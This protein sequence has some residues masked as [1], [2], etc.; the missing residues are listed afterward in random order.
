MRTFTSLILPSIFLLQSSCSN[1]DIEIPEFDIYAAKN[2]WEYKPLINNNTLNLD[3]VELS[4]EPFL[5]L[6]KIGRY[7]TAN[8]IIMLKGSKYDL[9]YPDMR[10]S[11]QLFVVSINK[12]PVYG[13]FFWDINSSQPCRW[14][15]ILKPPDGI[16]DNQIKIGLGYATDTIV[17]TDPRSDP[18]VIEAFRKSGKL[19]YAPQTVVFKFAGN[20]GRLVVRPA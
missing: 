5:T 9:K 14:V 3:T 13:G 6:D 4:E 20:A 18:R 8:H 2:L 12:E 7:D 16:P 17:G 11:G 15:V 19:I 10:L 1:D